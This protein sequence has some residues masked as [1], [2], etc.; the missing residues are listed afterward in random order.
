[1]D[2]SGKAFACNHHEVCAVTI[3]RGTFAGGKWLA[4]CLAGHLRYQCLDQDVIVE[5]AAA[6]G[7]SQEELRA[8][9][10]KPPTFLERLSHK[11]YLY[12]ALVQA[13]L[14]E[15]RRGGGRKVCP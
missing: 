12:L 7:I 3:S 4:E 15:E 6:W 8:A 5:K 11:R 1:L 2:S 9:R 13:P 14:T 10:D